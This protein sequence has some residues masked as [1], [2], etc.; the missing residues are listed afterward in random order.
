[1]MEKKLAEEE[2]NDP[3]TVCDTVNEVMERFLEVP[4]STTVL[5]NKES[6]SVTPKG[7]EE[8]S[9][10]VVNGQSVLDSDC[11]IIIHCCNCL[12][13]MGAGIAK[14]LAFEYPDVYQKDLETP[15]NTSLKLGCYSSVLV[16][17]RN[18]FKSQIPY[19][20]FVNLYGQYR[21][22]GRG[23]RYACYKA[24]RLG[25]TRFV[26]NLKKQGCPPTVKI[27]TYWLGCYRA[28]GEM[29]YVREIFKRAFD[30][31]PYKLF[32]Y[33]DKKFVLY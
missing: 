4:L 26:E 24:I 12:H 20:T 32:V 33:D 31:S 17:N 2:E 3:M 21:Y 6:R 8:N 14:T 22:G 23:R 29:I 16:S 19:V 1:M 15:Y 25:I 13:K 5:R 7:P 27:G 10:V 30:N 28:G 9:V 18:M 11:D